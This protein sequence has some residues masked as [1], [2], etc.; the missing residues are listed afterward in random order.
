MVGTRGEAGEILVPGL[1]TKENLGEVREQE[2][3]SALQI[4]GVDGLRL[5]G[6]RDSGMAGSPDND[7]PRAYVKQDVEK[8]ASIV[9]G[10][11]TEI[12]PDIVLTYGPD[13]IY[14]HPD[15]IMAHRVGTRAVMRAADEGWQTPHVYYSAAA[16]GR[17]KWMAELPDGPF[18]KMSAGEL[19]G[20]GYL[21]VRSRPG[22]MFARTIRANWRH[23]G[24]IARRWG[25]TG[26][27]RALQ[28]SSARRSSASSLCAPCRYRG[29][30]CLWTCW[31]DSFPNRRWITRF[32]SNN[33]GARKSGCPC[34]LRRE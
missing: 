27:L 11:L 20:W 13:G 17:I 2:L 32:D 6:Y 7:D 19:P 29:I 30:Q 4:L 23:C 3:R 25:T 12:R 10:I 22:W 28:R 21:Q 1:A 5:L 15:H 34:G 18:A 31:P 14:G 9:A 24:R 16:K 33:R 8:V 26:R